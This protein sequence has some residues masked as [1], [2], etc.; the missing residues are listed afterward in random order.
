MGPF[1]HYKRPRGATIGKDPGSIATD[2][3]LAFFSDG[4]DL[5]LGVA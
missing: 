1:I 3:P 2:D 5:G 4:D